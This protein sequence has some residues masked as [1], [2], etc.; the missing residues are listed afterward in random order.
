M[1]M[2]RLLKQRCRASATAALTTLL[3]WPIPAHA[4]EPLP[5]LN[6]GYITFPPIAYMD[7]NG[8]A[9]GTIIKLTNQLAADSGYRLN[10]IN[11]PI[12]RIYH[13]L[14]SG[15]IDFWP[16]SPNVPALQDF[17]LSSKPL[18]ISVKLCAFSLEN[19]KTITAIEQLGDKQLVLIRGY[20]YRDQLKAIFENNPHQPIV[21]PNHPAAME[22]LHRGRGEYLISYSHPMQE[23]M[24]DYPLQDAHCDTL[25]DWPLVYV[26]SR[27]NPNAQLIA[28][29]FD[30]AY[31]RRLTEHLSAEAAPENDAAQ[32]SLP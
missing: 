25:D 24:K 12:N 1:M 7:D 17:T 16:G 23:A 19:S 15:D 28:D 9:Q 32:G 2:R 6:A 26:I 21:A 30:A 3:T 18:G 13:S 11:Y 10:W 20:T 14:K 27:R 5:L 31:E 22:L 8:K 4:H 29:T